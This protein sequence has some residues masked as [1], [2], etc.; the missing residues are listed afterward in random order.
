MDPYPW[1]DERCGRCDW[2]R[3]R[4]DTEGECRGAPPTTGP[5]GR[6][7]WPIVGRDESTCGAYRLAKRGPSCGNPDAYDDDGFVAGRGVLEATEA[8]PLVEPGGVY[9]DGTERPE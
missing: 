8:A 9:I 5:D 4:S 7:R 2:W 1:E 6:G 3:R